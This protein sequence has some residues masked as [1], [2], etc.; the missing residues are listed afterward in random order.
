MIA[1]LNFFLYTAFQMF[2][3][4]LPPYMK[5]LGATDGTIGLLQGAATVATLIIRP[6][7]GYMLDNFGRKMVL[8]L[9]MGLC[10][11][12]TFA[13]YFFPV[14]GIILLLR[15]MQGMGTGM[16]ST[17][18]NTVAVDCVPKSRFGEGMGYFTLSANLAM[19]MAPAMALAMPTGP[20]IIT[21]T[22]CFGLAFSLG[23]AQRYRPV[24]PRPKKTGKRAFPYEK[25]AIIPGVILMLSTCAYGSISSFIAIYA[26]SLG[27]SS[28]IGT[29]F[30]VYAAIVLLTRPHTG[31]IVDRK[32]PEVL[33][34]PALAMNIAGLII[35]SQAT[36]F[37]MFLASAAVFGLGQSATV[38]S[39]QAMAMLNAPADRK[40]AATAT[41]YTGFDLG[42]GGGAMLSGYIASRLGYSEMFMLIALLPA[43]GLILFLIA[44][45]KK[46]TKQ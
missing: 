2:P 24:R 44:A 34:L 14:I 1:L 4:A 7:T 11:A 12:V 27:I 39:T 29:Y 35:L 16:G 40:G 21:T 38:T 23:F 31:K 41:F 9:S 46:P 26:H 19:A 8:C 3:A 37:W 18:S 32:G 17:A 45:R 25:T 5:T 43:M 42:L 10:T 20:M 22:V 36:E 30:T 6:I 33:V 28:N 13:F 15:F